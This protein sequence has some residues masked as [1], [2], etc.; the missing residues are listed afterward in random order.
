MDWL[1]Q[2]LTSGVGI[3]IGA[4]LVAGASAA[5]GA[6][7]AMWMAVTVPPGAVVAF[8]LDGEC[9]DGWRPHD[10]TAGRF[11]RGVDSNPERTPAVLF[12]G[13]GGGRSLEG[14]QYTLLPSPPGETG[15][16]AFVFAK[17]PDRLPPYVTL[18]FC[19]PDD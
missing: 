1:K 4:L 11:I 6:L 10:L 3:A 16:T 2:V 18:Q 8:D 13:Q 7:G 9:P 19:T 17:E 5:L 14:D 12:R 15:I